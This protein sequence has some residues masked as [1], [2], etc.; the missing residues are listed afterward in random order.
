MGNNYLKS[1]FKSQKI[2][3]W[4]SQPSKEIVEIKTLDSFNI[5]KPTLIKL[6]VEGSELKVIQ[7]A[8]NTLNKFKPVLWIEIHTDATLK[9]EGFP[10]E[11]RE[12]ENI[13]S[14]LNYVYICSFS[15]TNH[16]FR[17]QSNL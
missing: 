2:K 1:T 8:R 5:E 9:A 15:E 6:D 11:R 10:Y 7:G 14:E 16:F 13:L 4:G 17:A 12:I 3:K